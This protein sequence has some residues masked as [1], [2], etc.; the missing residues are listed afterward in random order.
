MRLSPACPCQTYIGGPHLLNLPTAG[1]ARQRSTPPHPQQHKGWLPSG[2][3]GPSEPG[4]RDRD[5]DENFLPLFVPWP[6]HPGNTPMYTCY[7]LQCIPLRAALS[8]R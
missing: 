2:P 4:E 8:E 7:L 1:T 6:S 5:V 3:S